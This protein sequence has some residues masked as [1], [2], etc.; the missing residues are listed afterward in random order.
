M[1]LPHL[2]FISK[3]EGNR[4]HPLKP[5]DLGRLPLLRGKLVHG[6]PSTHIG[7]IKSEI[8]LRIGSIVQRGVHE[9]TTEMAAM[10]VID[11][12]GEKVDLGFRG[13]RISK[14]VKFPVP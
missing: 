8:N 4:A 13:D 1:S 2:Q 12:F 10:L 6:S 7:I 11:Q 14:G 5:G 9:K 3:G